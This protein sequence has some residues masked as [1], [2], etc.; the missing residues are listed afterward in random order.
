MPC[1]FSK[2]YKPGFFQ[3]PPVKQPA[4]LTEKQPGT[5][6]IRFRRRLWL[7]GNEEIAMLFVHYFCGNGCGSQLDLRDL[8][9]S[10]AD[11]CGARGQQSVCPVHRRYRRK[12]AVTDI[13]TEH[14]GDCVRILLACQQSC[15]QYR[16]TITWLP[17]LGP[18]FR[19]LGRFLPTPS[20]D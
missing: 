14:M 4:G 20:Q 11:K 8:I 13:R 10:H 1:N 18:C 7:A 12:H 17:W 15:P 9:G 19:Y 16:C 2:L 6:Q 5:G 3:W